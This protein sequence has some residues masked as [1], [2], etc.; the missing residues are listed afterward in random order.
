M[1]IKR[2]TTENPVT[3]GGGKYLIKPG[4]T[5]RTIL[6]KIHQDPTVYGDDANI[7]RPD[8]ML[9]E[10]FKKLPKNAWKVSSRDQ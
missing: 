5:L 4:Q 10:N 2:N 6:P 1:G 9:D 3:I 8:R 7:F